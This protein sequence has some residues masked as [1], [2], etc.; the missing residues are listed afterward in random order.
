MYS[1]T[2]FESLLI[3]SLKQNLS[4]LFTQTEFGVYYEKSGL[5]SER[6]AA[7]ELFCFQ[8]W[9]TNTAH[10]FHPNGVKSVPPPIVIHYLHQ[11]KINIDF[12]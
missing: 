12:Q 11:N 6:Q 2:L 9:I 7:F 10:L 5:S 1:Q 3:F 4:V 8:F